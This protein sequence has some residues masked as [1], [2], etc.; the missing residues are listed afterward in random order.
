MACSRLVPLVRPP[1]WVP[2]RSVSCAKICTREKGGENVELWLKCIKSNLPG[3]KA[4]TC[5]K[6]L[7]GMARAEECTEFGANPGDFKP[8]KC[9]NV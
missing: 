8:D 1:V 6:A 7:S 2:C 5:C 3:C 4:P 9:F